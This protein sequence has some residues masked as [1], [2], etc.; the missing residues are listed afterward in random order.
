MVKDLKDKIETRAR[1]LAAPIQHRMGRLAQS[2]KTRK[3]KT[4]KIRHSVRDE[5]WSLILISVAEEELF[6]RV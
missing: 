1:T 3:N 6:V 5:F 2:S 4:K